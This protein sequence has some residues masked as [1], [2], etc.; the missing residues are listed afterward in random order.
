MH[1]SLF[2]WALPSWQTQ[3]QS[4]SETESASK[5][6]K[7]SAPRNAI[8]NGLDALSLGLGEEED[9]DEEAFQRELPEYACK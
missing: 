1:L 2:D 6:G 8:V 9:E 5:F 7:S 3:S 4:Q